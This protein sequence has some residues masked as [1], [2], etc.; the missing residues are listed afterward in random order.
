MLYLIVKYIGSVTANCFH[1]AF[2]ASSQQTVRKK[3]NILST[4]LRNQ[5]NSNFKLFLKNIIYKLFDFES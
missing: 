2:F 3:I 5:S 1:A 4:R